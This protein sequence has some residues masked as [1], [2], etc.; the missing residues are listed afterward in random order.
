MLGMSETFSIITTGTGG[1]H[2]SVAAM[3][4]NTNDAFVGI[5]GV[6][7]GA[8]PLGASWIGYAAVYDAGTE[9]VLCCRRNHPWPG[10]R[11]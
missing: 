1:S 4:V 10:R 11:R 6:N 9:A 5:Q 2:V 8:L 3:P 7:V